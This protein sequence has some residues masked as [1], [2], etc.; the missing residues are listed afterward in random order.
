MH[1]W[2]LQFG[3]KVWTL[4]Q[5]GLIQFCELFRVKRDFCI[6]VLDLIYCEI[7]M[8][9]SVIGE[10]VEPTGFLNSSICWLLSLEVGISC[11]ELS[12]IACI[13]C[14]ERALVTS[15][16]QSPGCTWRLMCRQKCQYLQHPRRL[17]QLLP[18]PAP[19]SCL[20]FYLTW[21]ALALA[22][23]ACCLPEVFSSPRFLL[24]SYESYIS[25]IDAA[26]P[27]PGRLQGQTAAG[28][29]RKEASLIPTVNLFLLLA[30]ARG[31]WKSGQEFCTD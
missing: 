3:T 29:G 9:K 28:G 6:L 16:T 15:I 18:L 11:I 30:T 2:Y 17:T 8:T 10:T 12:C 14:L 24:L 27:C 5:N 22:L 7:V 25:W 26:L 20:C 23:W 1:I 31:L 4:S 19:F 13:T 21:A